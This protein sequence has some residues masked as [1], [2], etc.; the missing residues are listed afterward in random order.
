[1]AGPFACT[2]PARLSAVRAIA[3]GSRPDAFAW[4]EVLDAASMDDADRG[5]VLIARCVKATTVD[6]SMVRVDAQPGARAV[7]VLHAS[8]LSSSVPVGASTLSFLATEI[9]AEDVVVVVDRAG[10]DSTYTLLARGDS[11]DPVLRSVPF[12]FSV[13]CTSGACDTDQ[14][15]AGGEPQEQP[16]QLDTLARDYGDF[17]ALMLGRLATLL[18][19]WTERHEGDLGVALVESVA[20]IADRLAYYQDAVAREATIHTARSRVSVSRHARWLDRPLHEGVEARTWLSFTASTSATVPAGTEVLPATIAGAGPLT[21][22]A[23]QRALSQH[24]TVFTTLEQLVCSSERNALEPWDWGDEACCL[25]RGARTATVVDPDPTP[26]HDVILKL[27]DVVILEQVVDPLTGL[28]SAA[29]T[30]LRHPVRLDRDAE[31]VRDEV[32]GQD[33]LVLHWHEE[34]ALPFALPVGRVADGTGSWTPTARILG[35]VV[36]AEAGLPGDFQLSPEQVPADASF[37]P[38]LLGGRVAHVA[39]ADPHARERAAARAAELDPATA[40]PAVRLSSEEGLWSPVLEL[41]GSADSSQDF[42]VE[43]EERGVARLRFGDD[44]FGARP[45]RG[46][47]F[48]ASGRTAY[49]AAGNVGLDALVAMRSVSGITAVRNPLAAFGGTDPESTDVARREAPHAFRELARGVLPSDLATLAERHPLVQ[50]ARATRLG[51]MPWDTIRLLVD[52]VGGIGVDEAFAQELE[53]FLEPCRMMGQELVVGSP[54]HVWVDIALVVCAEPTW[55]R[56]AVTRELE[57]C[58]TEGLRADGTPGAFHPDRFT[59]GQ[60]LYRSAVYAQAEAVPG[61]QRLFRQEELDDMGGLVPAAEPRFRRVG[62]SDASVIQP[63]PLEILR[64]G[65]I[66]FDVRGGR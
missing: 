36:L 66:H 63:G 14:D 58:F 54:A 51:A 52:R 26:E 23:L 11:W 46:S 17:R 49:G 3:E 37:R 34:D 41:I 16:P 25:P 28:T 62:G 9:T 4:V 39:P 40:R 12:R 65:R 5:R 42:V 44:T 47:T 45:T 15:C 35:N 64:L 18:P 24:P 6:R 56:E 1:M 50:R 13:V 53:A 33:V 30:R 55:T 22:A 32:L 60:P 59:F 29:D 48:T 2:H 43:T 27:G 61:V 7:R 19:E 31:R 57:A 21:S 8:A 10:D 38:R 20:Y